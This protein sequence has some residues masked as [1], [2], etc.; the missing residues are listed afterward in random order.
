MAEP[1]FF[2]PR[3]FCCLNKYC[4]RLATEADSQLQR[5]HYQH[6]TEEVHSLSPFQWPAALAGVY[7]SKGWWRW[8]WQLDYW[9]CKLCKAPVKSPPPTK[10]H[11]DFFLQAGCPSCCPTNSVKALKGK[12]HIPWT[13]LPQA[14]LEGLPTLSLTTEEVHYWIIFVI[15]DQEYDLNYFKMQVIYF[16]SKVCVQT[17]K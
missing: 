9:S 2:E 16:S 8:W 15:N 4:N 17:I 14:H 10:Q 5:D 1:G 11:P 3:S 6:Y 13:C 7:W 12:Y